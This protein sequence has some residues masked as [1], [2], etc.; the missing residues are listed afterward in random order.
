MA[1]IGSL[2]Y[3]SGRPVSR[4]CAFCINL[5]TDFVKFDTTESLH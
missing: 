1:D 3:D 4:H 2:P 5:G